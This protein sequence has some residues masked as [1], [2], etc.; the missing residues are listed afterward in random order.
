MSLLRDANRAEINRDR[1]SLLG[2]NAW[3]DS[4]NILPEIIANDQPKTPPKA[5]FLLSC[6][7]SILV[8]ALPWLSL[9]HL[10][11]RGF[12]LFIY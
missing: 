5:N 6:L 10:V 1:L 11:N 3:R 4:C 2:T 7:F 12:V 9:I 8:V